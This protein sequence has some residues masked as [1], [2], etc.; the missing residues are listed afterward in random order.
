MDIPSYKIQHVL[1]AYA[2]RLSQRKT[3]PETPGQD[4][5][6]N[7]PEGRQ[8]ELINQISDRIIRR[9]REIAGEKPDRVGE[10]SAGWGRPPAASRPVFTYDE[11]APDGRRVVRTLS[12]DEATFL[13]QEE[14]ETGE[15]PE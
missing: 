7:A 4:R 2:R 14:S 3:D 11:V 12:L 6:R 13:P 15:G 8:R 9:A 5:S 10:A 1:E